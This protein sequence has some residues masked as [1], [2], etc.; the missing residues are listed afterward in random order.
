M[1][2]GAFCG[3]FKYG[4][5][6]IWAAY[7][8]GKDVFFVIKTIQFAWYVLISVQFFSFCSFFFPFLF[9]GVSKY[10]YL[11]SHLFGFVLDRGLLVNNPFR[12]TTSGVS[13]LIV[14]F[15]FFMP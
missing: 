15:S 8:S 14:W 11:L 7:H 13:C 4:F 3:K 2:V 5:C 6:V 12:H 9:L 10:R 1:L